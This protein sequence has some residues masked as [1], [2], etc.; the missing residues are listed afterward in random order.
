VKDHPIAMFLLGGGLAA[1]AIALLDRR[2]A[3]RRVAATLSPSNTETHAASPL[4]PSFGS[5]TG[6]TFPV[7]SLADRRAVISNEFAGAKHLGV[8]LM[9][10]RRSTSDLATV[11]RAGTP[12]GTKLFFMPDDVPALAASAG[13]VTFAAMTPVG[14]AVLIQHPN[15]W[16]TYYAHLASLSVKKGEHVV[17]GARL[18]VIGAS[19]QDAEHLKHL[20]FELWAGRARSGATDPAPYLV[21]WSRVTS[22]WTPPLLV[23][24]NAPRNGAMSA[25]RPVGDRGEPYPEWVRALRGKAGVYVIRDA[26]THECLYVGSSSTQLYDTLTRH[27]QTWRRY[28]GFWRGQYA[29]GADPGLTYPRGDVEVAVR[30]TSPSEALDTEMRLIARLRPRDNQIGQPDTAADEAIPF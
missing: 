11:Y 18:G 25:Y 19:P 28:K 26:S 6:W 12:N 3:A 16:T 4:P 13:T 9:F 23:A 5:S 14:N 29:E 27:L 24:S 22:P 21:A 20:H 10:Q 17:A 2:A 30:L 15:G 8:D 1:G 7:P